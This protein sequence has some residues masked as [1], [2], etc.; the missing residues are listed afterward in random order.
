VRDKR[1]RFAVGVQTGKGGKGPALIME[2]GK[3]GE[4]GGYFKGRKIS[5]RK[6]KKKREMGGPPKC[7]QVM[8][9]GLEKIN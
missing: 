3:T 2:A 8:N 1:K 7:S 5:C 9:S 4:W 6:V